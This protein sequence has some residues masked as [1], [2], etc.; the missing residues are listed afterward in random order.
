VAVHEDGRLLVCDSYNDALKWL[1]PATREVMTWVR[2]LHE[3]AGLAIAPE[4]V[5]VA[6]TNAHRI[7]VVDMATG[8]V[9]T[10]ELT[11]P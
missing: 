3:P 8:R 2:G 7:A 11:G 6:D 1:D 9:D 10:L 4:R 5:Y